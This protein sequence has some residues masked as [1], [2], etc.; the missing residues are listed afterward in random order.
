MM[1]MASFEVVA[2]RFQSA[3][4]R[5]GHGA[6]VTAVVDQ[7]VDRFLEHALFVVDDDIRRALALQGFKTVVAIDDAAV[8]VIEVAGRETAAIQGD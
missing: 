5:T 8:K 7:S 1:S 2:Q 3:A 6:A 4:G